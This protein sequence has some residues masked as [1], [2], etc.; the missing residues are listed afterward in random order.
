MTSGRQV[1][2]KAEK[3]SWYPSADALIHKNRPDH[4]VFC[5]RPH[6]AFEAGRWFKKTFPGR[7]FYAVKANPHPAVLKAL[8]RAG[9][10]SFDAASINEIELVSREVPNAQ[11]AF[12]H[13]VKPESSIRRA[14]YDFGIRIF[15]L[16][17]EAELD[18]ILRATD[19]APDL[20]LMV[21][22][23]VSSPHAV[24]PLVG[25]FG[26]QG[27]EAAALLLRARQIAPLLGVCVHAGSQL[28]D[29]AA[30]PQVMVE[31]GNLICQ[32]GVMVDIMD[33]GGG[34]PSAYP[35]MTPPP[36]QSYID[37]IADAFEVLPVLETCELWCEPGRALAAESGSVI[38]KVELRRHNLLYLNEGTYGSLFD[39]G[40]PGFIFPAKVLGR[41]TSGVQVGYS[42]YGPTCDSIDFMRGPFLLPND[43]EV[44]DYIEIGALGAYGLA[45]RTQFNGFGKIDVV[46]LRDA[47]LMSLYGLAPS[48]WVTDSTDSAAIQILD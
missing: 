21:R 44:G 34:F 22:I 12:L 37:A 5:L 1:Q 38:T 39:A 6:A 4:P 13:P 40:Q 8:A 18:K 25:K 45:L 46:E 30:I 33:I 28:L 16:D 11:I 3:I 48:S 26:C 7:V 10:D 19:N 9:I 27:A 23:G 32:A 43:I 35:G 20:T 15:A 42:L 41:E 31:T 29:P 47:P 36:L 2:P 17:S 14:Y 24:M